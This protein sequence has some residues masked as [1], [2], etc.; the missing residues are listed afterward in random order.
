MSAAAVTHRKL[1]ADY[2]IP[3]LIR[4]GW[5]LAG[6]HGQ[7]LAERAVD[8]MA[9]ADLGPALFVLNPVPGGGGGRGRFQYWHLRE[10]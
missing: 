1:S 10:R 2:Q 7:V 3:R 6:D 8:D 4:G 9:L 5:Q